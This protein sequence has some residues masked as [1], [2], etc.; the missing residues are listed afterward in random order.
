VSGEGVR[1]PRKTGLHP[2]DFEFWCQVSGRTCPVQKSHPAGTIKVA[3]V[4]TD[5]RDFTTELK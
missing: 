1:D 3:G 4:E 2:E 5:E